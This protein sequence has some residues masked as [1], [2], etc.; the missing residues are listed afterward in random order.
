M[1]KK[2]LILFIFILLFHLLTAKVS[3]ILPA[4]ANG[5]G[6][7]DGVDYVIWLNHYNQETVNGHK[8]GDFNGNGITDG[9]D[10]VI[11]LNNYGK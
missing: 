10:Y 9:L 4:D 1:I 7:V 6:M 8:D 5:D 2:Y 3:A 11:W